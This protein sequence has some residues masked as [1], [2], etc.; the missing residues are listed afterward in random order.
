MTTFKVLGAVLVCLVG[1]SVSA[2]AQD[3]SPDDHG[4]VLLMA[5]LTSYG[6]HSSA[7]YQRLEIPALSS[8]API[9][10]MIWS[11]CSKQP[12]HDQLGPYIVEGSAGCEITGD[13]LPLI[14]I[15][16]GKGGSL[17][18]HHDT[19]TALAK[20]G[21]VV[22][23]FNQPGDSFADEQET[24]N[25]R[26][27]EARP[28]DTS[29][30]IT[31]MLDTWPQRAKLDSRKVGVFGFS[32]GGYTALALA[33][34]IPSLSAASAQFCPR[35]SVIATGLCGQLQSK[36]ASLAVQ[37]DAR[38]RAAVVIDPLNLFGPSGLK[39]VRI[40]IQLWAS[41]LGG[42][43][44][45]IS[46]VHEIRKALPNEPELF[47]ARQAGHFAYLAPCPAKFTADAPALC[48]D[49]SGFDRT[50]WHQKMNSQVIRF[51]ASTLA[52]EDTPAML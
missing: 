38:V 36:V 22:I 17:L 6:Q 26:I 35:I 13:R 41:E 52:I 1:V 15:S 34:A 27:F 7:G 45:N 39:N 46:H 18:G 25:L 31:H 48:N 5:P 8:Q 10:A 20:A 4:D 23:T 16:H 32:R 24:N 43:G 28:T 40:P 19:A 33:G 29:R 30:V 2:C 51:F 9:T 12:T 3:V 11:P 47:I 37:S 44:V 49:P 14:V 21:F 50:S 42:D